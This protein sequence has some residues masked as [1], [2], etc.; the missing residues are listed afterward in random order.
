MRC[1]Q[2]SDGGKI[3]SVLSPSG[4]PSA[5]HW[6]IAQMGRTNGTRFLFIIMRPEQI[7]PLAAHANEQVQA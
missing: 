2:Y 3:R 4:Q 1:H 7:S 5:G 6:F